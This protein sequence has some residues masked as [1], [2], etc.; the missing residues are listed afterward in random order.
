MVVFSE[1][2]KLLIPI[3]E[4]PKHPQ[5]EERKRLWGLL[6]DDRIRSEQARRIHEHSQALLP[7]R[8]E[9]NKPRPTLIRDAIDSEEQP[10]R[11]ILRQRQRNDEQRVAVKPPQERIVWSQQLRSIHLRRRR[12]N[13]DALMIKTIHSMDILR[14]PKIE[15]KEFSRGIHI[16]RVKKKEQTAALRRVVAAPHALVFEELSM[17][18][19]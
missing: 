10:I 12:E 2:Y 1:N 8:I 17:R 14:V 7:L 19:R 16:L 11:G 4:Q 9:T 15:G 6:Q 13:V 18:W 3:G 5:P